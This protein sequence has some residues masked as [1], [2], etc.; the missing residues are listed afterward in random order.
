MVRLVHTA[1]WQIGKGYGNM[2]EEAACLLRQARIGAIDRIGAAA[3]EFD[4]ACVVVAG[5]LWDSPILAMDTVHECF[6]AI[7]RVGRPVFVI[8]GNHDHGGSDGIWH[9]PEVQESQQRYA[10]NLRLLTQTE[11]VVLPDLVV[12]PCP[13]LRRHSATDSTAWLHSFPWHTLPVDRPRLVLAHGSVDHFGER[14]HHNVI[15]LDQLPDAAVDY[16]ALGDWHGLKQVRPKAWYCG[17]PE[18]DCFDKD[19]SGRRAQVLLVDV[20][21]GEMPHVTAHP[22]GYFHWHQLETELSSA[23]DLHH[24]QQQVNG[25]IGNRVRRDLLSLELGHSILDFASHDCYVEWSRSLHEQLLV[26]VC[27]G[28]CTAVPAGDDLDALLRRPHDPLICSV[29]A[30]LQQQRLEGESPSH[31]IA[32]KALAELFRMVR[33]EEQSRRA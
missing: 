16:V 20:E 9:R 6:H 13:L 7:G 3:E 26:V 33:R 1:D 24:L 27:K 8:P 10:P 29:A 2:A 32:S 15:A 17:T 14:V 25:C 19:S 22:T 4:A 30:Q 11:P 21:R 5:D 28:S 31:E 23:E 18:P 12:L